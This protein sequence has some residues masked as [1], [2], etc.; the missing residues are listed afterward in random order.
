MSNL[1]TTEE[2]QWRKIADA[3]WQIHDARINLIEQVSG[4]VP[5]TTYIHTFNKMEHNEIKLRSELEERY[6]KEHDNATTEM[7]YR[8]E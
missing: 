4:N 2:E 8:S 5:K 1:Q 3:M 7:F 6:Y